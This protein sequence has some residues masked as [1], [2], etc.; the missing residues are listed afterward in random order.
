M[1]LLFYSNTL[2][3]TL[4]AVLGIGKFH[5]WIS[6]SKLLT[7]ITSRSAADSEMYYD[8]VL[9]SAIKCVILNILGNLGGIIYISSFI[10]D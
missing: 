10:G 4:G 9:L 8:S 2:H 1:Q 7:A 3:I 5:D 6:D